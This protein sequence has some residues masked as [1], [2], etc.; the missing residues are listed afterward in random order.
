MVQREGEFVNTAR[1]FRKL[2]LSDARQ[3]IS[4]RV[5]IMNTFLLLAFKNNDTLE[6]AGK[7][8]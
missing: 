1:L 2:Q 4:V 3:M 5:E 8:I 6:N 7:C